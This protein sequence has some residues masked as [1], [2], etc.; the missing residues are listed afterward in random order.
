MRGKRINAVIP[1]RA[2]MR[3]CCKGRCSTVRRPPSVVHPSNTA[4]P[5]WIRNFSKTFE[6][7][8]TMTQQYQARDSRAWY[9][10]SA[11]FNLP[12]S[13]AFVHFAGAGGGW[14]IVVK[15]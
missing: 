4:L 13:A 2:E 12:I 7:R 6:L 10:S 11:Y 1:E 8:A 3:A 9:W 5:Q 15:Y 14:L